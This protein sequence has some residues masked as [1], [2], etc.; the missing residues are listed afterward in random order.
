M[1]Q[2]ICTYVDHFVCVFVKSQTWNCLVEGICIFITVRLHMGKCNS[3]DAGTRSILGRS[4]LEETGWWE[5]GEE[6][7]LE[8]VKITSGEMWWR[9]E[10][11]SGWEK[12]GR[13]RVEETLV[14]S[15]M[16]P[17]ETGGITDNQ[18]SRAPHGEGLTEKQKEWLCSDS[19]KP[20]MCLHR[21][22]SGKLRNHHLR[23]GRDRAGRMRFKKGWRVLMSPGEGWSDLVQFQTRKG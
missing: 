22:E 2:L 15:L 17:E 19:L 10:Q 16:S 21:H 13:A 6:T 18:R 23:P 3:K 1:T 9:P 20:G 7:S 11:S 12:W 14:T 4:I 8:V 5:G